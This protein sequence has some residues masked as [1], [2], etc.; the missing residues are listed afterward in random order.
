[1]PAITPSFLWD[2][3]SNMRVISASEYERLTRSL[4]WQR[5]MKVAPKSNSKRER[6]SWLLDT[7][8]IRPTGKG[9]NMP[10]EDIVGQTTEVEFENA[11]GGLKLKKEQFED[12]DG[13]G[14]DLA[15]HWSR[16]MGAY[17][18]Y[19]PQ[20]MLAQQ[21]LKNSGAGPTTYDGLAF[22]ATNHP[23]NPFLTAAGTYS[24]VFTG[25]ASG[26]YPGA[27][28]IDSSVTVE[29]AI[30]NIA[31]ALAYIASLKMPNGEDPRFLRLAEMIVPPALEARAR[32][33]TG[34]AFIATG[35]LGGGAGSTDITPMVRN[36]GLSAEPIVAPELGS[37]FSGGSD[38]SFYLAM[39]EIT[40]NPLGAFSYVP[41][42]EFT[43]LF[44]GPQ[45][46]AQLARIKEFQWTTEGR[47]N[48]LAGHP[49]LLFKCKAA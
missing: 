11:A 2:L 38:T 47:N 35:A 15:A 48:V 27:L 43:M 7:A 34:A 10:F 39:E 19:W 14:I 31:K 26:I 41:R 21:F 16:Q 13:N 29:E 36:F 40:T 45:N 12:L 8:Q 6:I 30:N 42:D 4:W 49:Y 23:Y 33:V 46:D 9:G 37:G 3:E 5:I 17:S 22:F 18:S 25:S 28:K 44:Y 20:K 1:M 32:M 24:N